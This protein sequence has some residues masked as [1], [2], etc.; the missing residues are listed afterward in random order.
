MNTELFNYNLNKG[1][2]GEDIVRAYLEQQ[3]Y[4][5]YTPDTIGSHMFDI[6]AIKNKSEI[7]IADVK[8]KPKRKNYNDTGIDVHFY[9]DYKK[10]SEKM[11]V[12]FYVFFVDYV[13]GKIY[14]ADIIDLDKKNEWI[15]NIQ[16]PSR[17]KGIIYYHLNQLEIIGELSKEDVNKLKE[18]DNQ[19]PIENEYDDLMEGIL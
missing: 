10:A 17:Y 8:T 2:I 15:E 3:G 4:V 12:P 9:N 14:K 13:T 16:Y 1:K 6:M 11:N 5:V 19:K 18:L 7:I